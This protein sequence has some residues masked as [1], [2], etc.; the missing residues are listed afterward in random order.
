MA[1]VAVVLPMVVV[2]ILVVAAIVELAAIMIA[3]VKMVVLLVVVAGVV[4]MLREDLSLMG[5]MMKSLL[6][7][8]TLRVHLR[9]L[10]CLCSS[11]LL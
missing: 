5:T 7:M 1:V 8:S 11:A 2:K 4:V 3:T 9:T 10:L 6:K